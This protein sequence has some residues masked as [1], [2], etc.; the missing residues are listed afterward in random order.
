MKT[1]TKLAAILFFSTIGTNS[2]SATATISACQEEVCK[3]YFKQ[4]K[5]YARLG[6]ADAMVT[7]AELYYYGHGTE[8][9]IKKALKQY[10]SSAKYGSVKGQFK[11]AMIYLNN[12]EHRDLDDGIKY[13]KKAARNGHDTASLLLGIIYFSSDN[14]KQDFKEADKWLAKAHKKKN[15]KIPAFIEHIKSTGNFSANNF[16]DLTAAIE[17]N[18]IQIAS[19]AKQAPKNVSTASSSKKQKVEVITVY[20]SL[21]DMFDAQ[22]ASLRNTYPEKGAQNTGS[23]IAGK[24]CAQTLACGTTSD[25]DFTR[26]VRNIMGDQAVAMFHEEFRGTAGF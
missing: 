6:Y 12:D 21:I 16:P 19:E 9:N 1:I 24:T 2:F 25:E 22:L 17:E 26:G 15:K 20:G 11:T 7:L 3:D 13:L 14:H 23:R 8:K 4:Y 10:K 18:P 5:K